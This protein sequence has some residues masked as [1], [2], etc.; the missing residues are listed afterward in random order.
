MC[1]GKDAIKTNELTNENV[2]KANDIN[3]D[4]TIDDLKLQFVQKMQ[5]LPINEANV[6]V[7]ALIK[8]V[9]PDQA[10]TIGNNIREFRKARGLKQSDLAEAIG[11]SKTIISRYEKGDACPSMSRLLKIAN[12][13]GIPITILI[14]DSEDE[15]DSDM[16]LYEDKPEKISLIKDLAL[17]A[18]YKV[19]L[20]DDYQNKDPYAI[21][22]VLI[23]GE[24]SYDI[25]PLELSDFY[26]HVVDYFTFL[27]SRWIKEK[28]K[29]NGE[30]D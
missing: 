26:S 25:Y 12:A 17:S 7:A 14:S 15:E 22:F 6:V 20:T 2:D 9:S 8:S 27:I 10:D 3:N 19:S 11:V 16:S 1:N 24:N 4:A 13:L 30:E 21:D 5:T 29:E 28:E 23:D 18:G